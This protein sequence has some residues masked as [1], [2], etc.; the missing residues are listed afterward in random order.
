MGAIETGLN[1]NGPK[2]NRA[3]RKGVEKESDRKQTF[4]SF[5]FI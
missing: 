1:G 3:E 2:R 5:P 4:D